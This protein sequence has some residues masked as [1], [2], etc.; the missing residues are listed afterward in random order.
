MIMATDKRSDNLCNYYILPLIGL[1]KLSFGKED[2][3]V[4]SYLT[5]DLCNIVVK[6]KEPLGSYEKHKAYKTDYN[7]ED[8]L[9]TVI[10]T[11]PQNFRATAAKFKEGAYSQFSYEAKQLIKTKSGLNYKVPDG[12]GSVTSSKKL[13]ALD[14]DKDLRTIMEKELA[15]KISPDAELYS[16]P[17]PHE[18]ISLEL[19]R[20]KQG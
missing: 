12:K 14:K 11:L 3:F 13:L 10:F 17:E 1:N 2:N 16:I 9:I 20:V 7:S 4:N 5:T 15:V 19:E 8:G 18:F 6:L